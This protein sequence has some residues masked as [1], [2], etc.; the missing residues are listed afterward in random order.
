MV[1]CTGPPPKP[2]PNCDHTVQGL[3]ANYSC[4]G[5]FELVGSNTLKCDADSGDGE[6]WG[7]APTSRGTS[8]KFICHNYYKLFIDMSDGNDFMFLFHS[9]HMVYHRN[10]RRSIGDY[11]EPHCGDRYYCDHQKEGSERYEIYSSL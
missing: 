1:I 4:G 2:P 8:S 11:T 3:Y 9:C 5:I 7:K 6:G 10:N